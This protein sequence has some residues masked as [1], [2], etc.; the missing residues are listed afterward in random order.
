MDGW[1]ERD[2]LHIALYFD[3]DHK[4]RKERERSPNDG[5]LVAEWWD[6]GAREMFEDGFFN[7]RDLHGSVLDYCKSVGI[8]KLT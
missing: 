5:E 8:V 7:A 1:E 6:D 4:G 2:R 3:P